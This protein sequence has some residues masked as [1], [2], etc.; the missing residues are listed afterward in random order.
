MKYKHIF[1]FL[2]ALNLSS[3]FAA[4]SV[5]TSS[6]A[7]AVGVE[8]AEPLAAPKTL[9]ASTLREAYQDFLSYFTA[10]PEKMEPGVRPEIL[11][12]QE[13]RERDEEL[14]ALQMLNGS[15]FDVSSLFPKEILVIHNCIRWT[16]YKELVA[17]QEDASTKPWLRELIYQVFPNHAAF[18]AA[19]KL[20]A[21][22]DLV[23]RRQGAL[24]LYGVM[25]DTTDVAVRRSAAAR[26]V[27]VH[28]A[29]HKSFLNDA[30]L[31]VAAEILANAVGDSEISSG[32]IYKAGARM[33]VLSE[34]S[35]KQESDEQ[36]QATLDT[37]FSQLHR[38]DFTPEK[39]VVF[40]QIVINT[41][42]YNKD[43]KQYVYLAPEAQRRAAL[44]F[45]LQMIAANPTKFWFTAMHA[46][47]NARYEEP[48]G[49]YLAT[50]EQ[51]EMVMDN[52][53]RYMQEGRNFQRSE[54][55]QAFIYR[56]GDDSA[57]RIELQKRA[58]EVLFGLL[59]QP[60][61][62]T[63][64]QT[65]VAQSILNADYFDNGKHTYVANDEMRQTAV[66]K[67]LALM[68]LPDFSPCRASSCVNIIL[69]S[70]NAKGAY[71]ASLDEIS[72][73]VGYGI[74]ALNNPDTNH[75]SWLA[76]DLLRV[77]S[78]DFT[79]EQIAVIAPNALQDS[80]V[81]YDFCKGSSY[82]RIVNHKFATL[83]QREK[84]LAAIVSGMA[85]K[86]RPLSERYNE[87]SF[88][89]DCEYATAE[90]K[91]AAAVVFAEQKVI[92][93]AAAVTAAAAKAVSTAHQIARSDTG[94]LLHAMQTGNLLP[95]IRIYKDQVKWRISHFLDQIF[96]GDDQIGFI[97]PSV[98]YKW[99]E[100]T[101]AAFKAALNEVIEA[102]DLHVDTSVDFKMR[103][104]KRA[105]TAFTEKLFAQIGTF[106][107]D[108]MP[109]DY[110]V[111]VLDPLIEIDQSV[112]S[113]AYFENDIHTREG[114]IWVLIHG[115]E[116]SFSEEKVATGTE[117]IITAS[118][119]FLVG[120][121]TSLLLQAVQ[122]HDMQPFVSFHKDQLKTKINH[123]LNQVFP[124]N[125]QIMLIDNAVYNPSLSVRT[126]GGFKGAINEIIERAVFHVSIP[127]SY[128]L[129]DLMSAYRGVPCALYD[130]M[131]A[132]MNAF[133]PYSRNI[134]DPSVAI[135]EHALHMANIQDDIR[136]S[137][138]L[139]SAFAGFC[140]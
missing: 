23:V 100:R 125:E 35:D 20:A 111:K 112:L 82:E 76:Q 119:D 80:D 124:G 132:F 31:E 72:F 118:Q 116:G 127:A 9:N 77:Y 113:A 71:L 69:N 126:K 99:P 67:L 56:E 83:E 21:S 34:N 62:S 39:K 138:G 60:F 81:D 29:D 33:C 105:S 1:S 53:S 98:N 78:Q 61:L 109:G 85:D 22:D 134:I 68:V 13:L 114:L 103:D 38:S 107:N 117:L 28:D 104:V 32:D 133:V 110:D 8:V 17:F 52:L 135:D 121:D 73:A 130:S 92:D 115:M 16:Y 48:V 66:K 139:D 4:S 84:A 64:E 19:L 7:A 65:A 54:A 88:I 37:L 120:T 102:A 140:E 46:R 89:A 6:A 128:Q 58:V 47:K 42:P 41:G 30:Q 87:A 129:K 27:Y 11:F 55:A 15:A 49:E 18:Q 50:P 25:T 86:A 123:F 91:A 136:T 131:S 5:A 36:R 12:A 26:I 51:R 108:L 63:A 95:Y 90:Q 45:I 43:K 101:K 70:I 96:P 40:A 122:S 14:L 97:D 93:E 24:D 44:D 3:L 137:D 10:N 74:T 57:K 75:K 59:S 2:V 94:L 106:M 79:A